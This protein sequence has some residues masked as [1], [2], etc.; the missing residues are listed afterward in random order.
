MDAGKK[1]NMVKQKIKKNLWYF[2]KNILVKNLE[3]NDTLRN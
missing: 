3:L 1:Q 2:S